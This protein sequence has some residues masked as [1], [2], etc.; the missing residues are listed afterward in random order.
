MAGGGTSNASFA[1]FW[2]QVATAF[3]DYPNII[4]GLMN[5]PHD[6]TATQWIGSAN[7]AMSAIR[8]AGANQMVLVPGTY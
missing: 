6:Q 7:A 4:F 3:R 5:E 8:A 2:G 1:N